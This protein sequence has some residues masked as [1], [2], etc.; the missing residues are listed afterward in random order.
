MDTVLLARLQFALTIGFHFIFAPLSIGLAVLVVWLLFVH[1]RTGDVSYQRMA[2]FWTALTALTFAVGAATGLTMEFQFGTNWASYSRFVGDVFGPFLATEAIFAFF[3]ESTLL[4]VLLFGYDRMNSFFYL[5]VSIGVAGGAVASAFW[6]LASNSWMQTPAGYALRNGRAELDNYLLALFNPSMIPRFLH[7][8]TGAVLT[9][10]LFMLGISAWL[11]LKHKH[12]KLAHYSAGLALTLGLLTALGQLASGHYHA[13]QVAA[14]QPAKMAAFE[15][16]FEDQTHAPLLIFGIP[17]MAHDRIIYDIRIPSGLSV[18][19]GLRRDHLV[20]GLHSFPRNDWPPVPLTFFP[21][22]LMIAL[23]F[24][25]IGFTAV[26][27]YLLWRRR[28]A[29]HRWYLWLAV[30]STPLPFLA[31]ELGWMAAEVGRQPWLVYNVYR[32][33]EGISRVVPAGH[34]LVSMV[35]LSLVYLLLFIVWL[36]FIQRTVA[37]APALEDVDAS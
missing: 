16:I 22:H 6:I 17:D 36:V 3:L 21:F 32:T 4:Y 9:G 5:L 15:G 12:Q 24:Y 11:L 30:L 34:V 2:R 20:K 13:M 1:W 27:V 37:K 23:G 26:G 33:S 8:T 35:V 7:T 29:Q 18:L 28:L 10:C 14:T 25:F 31:N 19:L